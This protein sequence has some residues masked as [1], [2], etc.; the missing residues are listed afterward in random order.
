MW[1]KNL[2][3]IRPLVT[4]A[5]K[6][7]VEGHYNPNLSFKSDP[8]I[9]PV[10]KQWLDPKSNHDELGIGT[11]YDKNGEMYITYT[12][13]QVFKSEYENNKKLLDF[14]P[15]AEAELEAAKRQ[16][17]DEQGFTRDFDKELEDRPVGIKAI[18][19]KEALNGFV[20][21][22]I[23]TGNK[24]ND[25]FGEMI[26][27]SES[28]IPTQDNRSK[29]YEYETFDKLHD[30][31]F[32]SY[33]ELFLTP[34]SETGEYANIEDLSTRDQLIAGKYRNYKKDLIN[35]KSFLHKLQYKDLGFDESLD[36]NNDGFMSNN[37]LND[38]SKS[39][40]VE[41]LTSPKTSSE[42]EIAAEQWAWYLTNITRQVVEGRRERQERGNASTKKATKEASNEGLSEFAMQLI[43]K[44]SK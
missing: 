34:D 26:K 27:T 3:E 19:V 16:I 7:V 30:I 39:M 41:I 9:G 6:G 35:E 21:K 40:L 38:V 15:R 14:D 25:L 43:E 29:I 24:I 28:T 1:K 8:E 13:G 10:L 42:R 5:I 17:E 18:S 2:V 22:D 23:K 36:K 32:D 44:Y 20:R 37:E 4:S 33:K 31:A 12:P 11:H